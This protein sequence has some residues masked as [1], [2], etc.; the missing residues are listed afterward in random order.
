LQRFQ[1]SEVILSPKQKTDQFVKQHSFC[2]RTSGKNG[3][4]ERRNEGA[5][6]PTDL[7]PEDPL[8]EPPVIRLKSSFTT[9][10]MRVNH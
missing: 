1:F 7:A 8:Q 10:F 9:I 2:S 4:E 5:L 3:A 6:R